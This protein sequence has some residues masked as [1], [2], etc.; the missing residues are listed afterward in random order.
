MYT[1][2]LRVIVVEVA[3]ETTSSPN[4]RTDLFIESLSEACRKS[5]AVPEKACSI[6][7]IRTILSLISY[8]HGP[9][10]IWKAALTILSQR[11]SFVLLCPG[12]VA[13]REILILREESW[14]YADSAVAPKLAEAHF[15]RKLQQLYYISAIAKAKVM[16]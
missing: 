8:T 2:T 4:H 12:K 7:T 11:Y 3:I 1:L 5:D 10:Y 14:K 6:K 15:V 16:R 13:S 9:E